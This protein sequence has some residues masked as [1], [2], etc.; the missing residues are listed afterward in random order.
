MPLSVSLS[1]IGYRV[2]IARDNSDKRSTSQRRNEDEAAVIVK[3][4]HRE[5]GK[6][7]LSFSWTLHCGTTQLTRALARTAGCGAGTQC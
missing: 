2:R 3:Y 7:Q 5:I 6:G 4:L 1:S